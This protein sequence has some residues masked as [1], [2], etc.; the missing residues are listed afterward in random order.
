ME[1]IGKTRS[2]YERAAEPTLTINPQK[3]KLKFNTSAIKTT[4][5]FGTAFGVAY[6][7]ET[8]SAF[9]YADEE[10]GIVMPNSGNVTNRYHARRLW[11]VLT[12]I[13][14]IDA[15]TEIELNISNAVQNAEHPGISFYEITYT[16]KTI[17]TE[18]AVEEEA[19]IIAAAGVEEVDEVPAAISVE[20]N[21]QGID[22]V[23]TFS[24]LN[25]TL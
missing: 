20:P 2:V 16:A 23:P 15:R 11:D 12:D 1:L 25:S 4:G 13:E 6:D 14:D 5:L 10:H 9:L 24:N 18:S 7:N 19:E 8:E 22:T 3:N 17:E 21:T